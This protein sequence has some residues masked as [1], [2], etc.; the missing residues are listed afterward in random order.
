VLELE[1]LVWAWRQE[2]FGWQWVA[3]WMSV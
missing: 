2:V 1:V 3:E